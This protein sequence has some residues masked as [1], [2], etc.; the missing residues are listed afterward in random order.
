EVLL[1]GPPRFGALPRGYYPGAGAKAWGGGGWAPWGG[2]RG[3][4][5]R[6]ARGGG[7][8]EVVG[9][10]V[11]ERR[12]YVAGRW[13]EGDEALPVENPA[14]ESQVAELSVTPDAEFRQAIDEAR[15]A[16]DEGPWPSMSGAERAKFLHALLDHIEANADT[17]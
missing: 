17:L 1:D 4:A 9:A 16:F 13:V 14:D 2:G 10:G 3:G 12:S 6:P 8:D 5:G 7:G 15:R 11:A